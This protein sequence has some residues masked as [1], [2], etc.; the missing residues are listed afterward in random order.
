MRQRDWLHDA[1]VMEAHCCRGSRTRGAVGSGRPGQAVCH[2]GWGRA[3][4]LDDFRTPSRQ[5]LEGAIRALKNDQ[6][7]SDLLIRLR[8]NLFR[9]FER[10]D[11]L[12]AGIAVSRA[13]QSY[14]HVMGLGPEDRRHAEKDAGTTH[15]PAHGGIADRAGLVP[16]RHGAHLESAIGRGG[17]IRVDVVLCVQCELAGWPARDHCVGAIGNSAALPIRLGRVRFWEAHV[18][19]RR[20][21]RV[22]RRIGFRSGR[23]R[24]TRWSRPRHPLFVRQWIGADTSRRAETTTMIRGGG[25]LRGT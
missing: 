25:S 12:G 13:G 7:G 5:Y 17:Q 19:R 22:G 20:V 21:A 23:A 9:S 2:R 14:Q 8:Q 4:V 10:G 11:S 15:R 16:R 6:R 24:T 1:P 18:G 3:V